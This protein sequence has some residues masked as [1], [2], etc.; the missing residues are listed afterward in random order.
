M[1]LPW[2]AARAIRLPDMH[3]SGDPPESEVQQLRYLGHTLLAFGSD[4]APAT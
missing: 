2:V 3:S 4:A 1:P